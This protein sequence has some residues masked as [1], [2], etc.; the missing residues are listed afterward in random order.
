MSFERNRV[1]TVHWRALNQQTLLF[2]PFSGTIYTCTPGEYGR[3]GSAELVKRVC[4]HLESAQRKP[5]GIPVGGSNALGSFGYIEAVDELKSQWEELNTLQATSNNIDH[6]V[7][8]CGSGGT[9]A[10]IA[11]GIAL[12]YGAL[13]PD[14]QQLPIPKVHAIGVCDS[15][16]YFYSFVA[17]IAEDMG[18][19]L[20]S[21]MSAEEFLRQH[22]IVHQGKNLGYAVSTDEE[23]DFI[24]NFAQDTG[25]VLDPVYSGKSLYNFVFD[26]MQGAHS[27]SFKGSNVIFIHTGG[28]LGMYDKCDAVMRRIAEQSPV[29]R[30]DVYGK[31]VQG[32][33]DIHS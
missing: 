11:V 7:F 30:L 10:G 32:S 14:S 6:I 29:K 9:A 15:P 18:L 22:M 5:Y 8:A 3:I 12:A 2:V 17:E 16:D 24:C 19:V 21:G 28:S 4:D 25:V 13:E 26:V 20:P 31:G 27:E 23:L 33:L 1:D